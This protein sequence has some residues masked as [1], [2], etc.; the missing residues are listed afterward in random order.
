[1]SGKTPEQFRLAP[2]TA[3][4]TLSDGG[5]QESGDD[6][7]TSSGSDATLLAAS[8]SLARFCSGDG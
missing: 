3:T 4:G 1:M 6:D 8:I 2:L 5:A 7:G